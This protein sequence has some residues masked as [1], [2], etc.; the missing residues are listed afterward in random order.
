MTFVGASVI[1]AGMNAQ[2]I[3]TVPFTEA[4]VSVPAK[5][6]FEKGNEFGI[7]VATSDAIKAN[8]LQCSVKNGVLN[9]CYGKSIEAG[10]TM[11]DE[12]NSVYYYGVSAKE[13][14][15]KDNEFVIT[16]TSPAMPEFKTSRD[17]EASYIKYVNN[18]TED[19]ALSAND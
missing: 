11:Y 19:V 13:M 3:V 18:S 15:T 14:D 12:K 9:I 8:L 5:V 7:S 4:C 2:E 16:V 17:Y 6:R 10:N 1:A